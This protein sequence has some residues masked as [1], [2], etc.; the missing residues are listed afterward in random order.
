MKRF[1]LIF[2]LFISLLFSN[3]D[4]PRCENQN[5][6]Y[7][8]HT[9]DSKIYNNELTR[10][11]STELGLT[12]WLK[13]VVSEND[14]DY[15]Q[16]YIYNENVCTVGRFLVKDW[17]PI[18]GIHKRK[19]VGYRNAQLQGFKYSITYTKTE[20]ILNFESLT[21]IIEYKTP[22]SFCKNRNSFSS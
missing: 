7:T 1:T 5:S 4:K 3:C 8:N 18:E 10:E 12:Y 13:D 20:T 16:V 11:L 6:I 17:S 14:N 19:G 22:L 2:I 21:G 15:L 9:I